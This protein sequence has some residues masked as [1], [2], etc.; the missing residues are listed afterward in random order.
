MN[1]A[2]KLTVVRII[3]IPL[4]M[5]FYFVGWNYIATGIF[6]IASITDILDG[7]IARKNNMVTVLGKFLDPLADK[8]LNITALVML[9]ADYS[10]IYITIATIIIIARELAVTGLRVLAASN[11]IVIAAD[12]WGKLKTVVQD[13]AIVV[14]ILKNF[15]FAL[16]GLPMHMI[17]LT[18]ALI[19]TIVSGYNYFSLNKQ[20][21]KV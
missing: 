15:P 10:N 8:L 12:K 7:N 4:M 19:L 3:L 1:L 5:L 11:N 9:V 21:F 18:I 17:L 16:I 2:N 20:V 6:I 14:L 13:I